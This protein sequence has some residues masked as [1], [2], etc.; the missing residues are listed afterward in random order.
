MNML[1]DELP[2]LTFPS[3]NDLL[4]WLEHHHAQSRG[5]WLRIFKKRAGI[6][7]VSFEDV[8][9]EGLCFGWSESSRR[10]Y[11]DLSYLQ[12][13]TPRKTVGTQSKRNIERARALIAA[14]RMTPSGLKALGLDVISTSKD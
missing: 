8:L 9:D 11:D 4:V 2:I 7:S 13:F 12:R 14:G 1:P 10:S 5:I 3:A 6:P